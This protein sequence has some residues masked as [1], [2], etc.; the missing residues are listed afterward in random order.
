MD[1]RHKDAVQDGVLLLS[2]WLARSASL[3]ASRRA[4]ARISGPVGLPR[5]VLG[6]I[7]SAGLFRTRFNF[8]AVSKV[9]TNARV[10]STAIFT[11][12][13]TGYRHDDKK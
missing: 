11:G 1:E 12:V 6:A 13:P 10:P 7:S 8:Q 4:R 9:R 2:A 5:V 3:P